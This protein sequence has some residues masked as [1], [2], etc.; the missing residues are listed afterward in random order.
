MTIN[1]TAIFNFTNVLT[2]DERDGEN[3]ESIF[4]YN[5]YDN[6]WFAANPPINGTSDYLAYINNQW[7][8]VF[9]SDDDKNFFKVYIASLPDYHGCPSE[10]DYYV[11][12]GTNDWT[13]TCN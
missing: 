12:E 6:V 9:Q 13:V 10:T 2:V 1:Y 7:T 5:Q 4:N 8:I 3:Y 11:A